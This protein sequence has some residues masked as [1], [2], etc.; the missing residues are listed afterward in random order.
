MADIRLAKPA[1]GTSQN[2]VCIPDARFVFEFSTDEATL[3]RNGDNLVITFE[4]G[5]TLFSSKT[6]I[7]PIPARICLPSL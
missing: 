5:S 6:F 7:R 1:A 4:D 3:S 2:I